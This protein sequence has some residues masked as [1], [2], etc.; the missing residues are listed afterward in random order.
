MRDNPHHREGLRRMGERLVGFLT[1]AGM[2]K[3]LVSTALWRRAGLLG[4][5]LRTEGTH[6]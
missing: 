6:A 2:I 4:P 1:A 3:G 5:G